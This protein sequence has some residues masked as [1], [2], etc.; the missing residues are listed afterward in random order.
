MKRYWYFVSTLTSFPFG[1]PPP[2]SVEEFDV[3]CSRFIEKSDLGLL[4]C[5]EEARKGEYSRKMKKSAFLKAYFEF[6]RGMRNALV[7]LR[8]KAVKMDAAQWTKPG[9]ISPEA[10]RAAQ[11]VQAA[12]DPLQAE[13][14][15][16]HERWKTVERLT[17]FSFFEMDSVL[18][19]KMKLLIATRCVSF[20]KDRGMEG[21]KKV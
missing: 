16:E 4:A 20:D 14:T 15:L 19:Y 9:N 17:A 6:E 18:A 12:A 3:L 7:G 11:A 8:A 2:V 13:L 21:L 5:A 10:L 1:T